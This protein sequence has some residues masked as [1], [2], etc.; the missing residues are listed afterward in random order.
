[1]R[2]YSQNLKSLYP[3]EVVQ[4]KRLTGFISLLQRDYGGKNDCT[5]TSITTIIKQL[6]PGLPTQEIYDKVEAIAKKHG[7]TGFYG[8]L[9]FTIKTIY[10]KS[11]KAFDI[12]YNI[13][14]KYLKNVCYNSN[15]IRTSVDKGYPMLLNMLNDG[16][17]YYKGHTVLIIGY[18][19]LKNDFLLIVLDNWNKDISYI[20]Y[21]KLSTISSIQTIN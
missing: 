19:E 15:T 5:L 7:Y 13:Q 20:D 4:Y 2:I 21:N 12:N 17:G 11:L 14:S 9:N 16:T 1:M 6:K 8:T 18:L 3:G 10:Q